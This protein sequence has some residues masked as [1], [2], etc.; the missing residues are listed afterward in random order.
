MPINEQKS[1]TT[2]TLPAYQKKKPSYSSLSSSGYKTIAGLPRAQSTRQ[3]D[4]EKP[5]EL[6]LDN[7]G[8]PPTGNY[9]NKHYPG[10]PKYGNNSDN[11]RSTSNDRSR[12]HYYS[13]R[14]DR[15]SSD[16]DERKAHRRR[17][18]YEPVSY[19]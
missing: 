2:N 10:N 11:H 6:E 17:N 12:P 14:S 8:R 19:A 1:P 4:Y 13:N 16:A 18:K 3:N 5:P 7:N 15:L 9:T